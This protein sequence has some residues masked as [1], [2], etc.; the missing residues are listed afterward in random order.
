MSPLI[1]LLGNDVL[2]GDF[3][4]VKKLRLINNDSLNVNL[5]VGIYVLSYLD[6]H[7]ND[8]STI[9]VSK[10]VGGPNG[11]KIGWGDPLLYINF[12]QVSNN[13]HDLVVIEFSR[14]D[15]LRIKSPNLYGSVNLKLT[16]YL[17]KY[18]Q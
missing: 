3:I 18:L 16:R 17:P 2:H 9:P 7:F 10:V 1:S 4:F 15:V 8:K 11:I 12:P 6:G 13:V 5:D 14:P